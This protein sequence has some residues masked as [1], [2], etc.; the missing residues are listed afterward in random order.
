M[1]SPIGDKWRAALCCFWVVC[2]P[3]MSYGADFFY[4][5][6]DAFTGRYIGPVGALV[7]SGDIE[8]GDYDRLL[9]RLIDDP[10]RFLSQNELILASSAGDIAEAMKIGRFLQALHT[11]ISVSPLTGRCVDACFFIYAAA[12]QRSAD[13]PGLIGMQAFPSPDAIGAGAFLRDNEVPADLVERVLRTRRGDV[14][15]LSDDDEAALGPRSPAFTRYLVAHCHWSDDIEREVRSARRPLADM[16]NMTTC[17]SQLTRRDAAAALAGATKA[18]NAR[19]GAQPR[20]Q[21]AQLP[22]Q[23]A[24]PRNQAAQP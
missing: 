3:L 5:D 22:N 6:H 24:Q 1:S 15:W 20:D 19:P 21:G 9:G 13:A 14:Y 18:P 12:D 7:M 2:M 11:E 8:R 16:K 23:G 17:R 4:M 10:Q